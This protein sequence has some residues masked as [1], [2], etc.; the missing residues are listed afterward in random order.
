VERAVGRERDRRKAAEAVDGRRRP[1]AAGGA[2]RGDHRA[3][4]DV[5][6]G[7]ELAAGANRDGGGGHQPAGVLGPRGDGLEGDGVAGRDGG[8]VGDGAGV[9]VGFGS[10]VGFGFGSGVGVGVVIAAGR[11]RRGARG[12]DD[13]RECEG[14]HG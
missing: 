3:L 9:G 13:D 14:A 12:D 10:G 4:V 8:R 5:V 1:R 2:L 7:D 11:A 6:G